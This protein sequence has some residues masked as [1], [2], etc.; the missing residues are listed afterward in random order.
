MLFG[1]FLPALQFAQECLFVVAGCGAGVVVINVCHCYSL[2]LAPV[3]E[4]PVAGI[5][6]HAQFAPIVAGGA[7]VEAKAGL[8]QLQGWLRRPGLRR[9]LHWLIAERL[10]RKST[11]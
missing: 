9:Q 4:L 3:E 10:D 8:W 6:A 11:R 5:N 2:E 7:E 1:V